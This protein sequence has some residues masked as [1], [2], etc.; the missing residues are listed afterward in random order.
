V[1]RPPIVLSVVPDDL[2]IVLQRVEPLPTDEQFDLIL[3]TNV[4]IYYDV[5]E[6]SLALAN[7]AR[8]LRPGGL[9]LSNDRIFELPGSLLASIGTSSVV[10]LKS[11]L[12]GERGDDVAWY[13]RY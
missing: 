13:R 5:F 1:I 6:Q 3:A 7:I 9:F 10:Y 11:S 2:N 8:M 4:L 12:G